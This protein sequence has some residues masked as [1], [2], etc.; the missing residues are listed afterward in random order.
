MDVGAWCGHG[1]ESFRLAELLES[2]WTGRCPRCGEQLAPGYT[3]V[4]STTAR[5]LMTAVEALEL[6]L[7][8][9]RDV[10]PR[11]HID[12]RRIAAELTASAE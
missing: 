12:V 11:L 3:S 1:G 5:Q 4:A 6:A 2:G 7:G 8:Q 10:A 9:L